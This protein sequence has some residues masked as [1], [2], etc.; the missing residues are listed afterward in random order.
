MGAEPRI[1][2]VAYWPLGMFPPVQVTEPPARDCVQPAFASASSR[3]NP[4]G[5]VN[6]TRLTPSASSS[7][8]AANVRSTAAPGAALAGGTEGCA[9]AGGPE[10]RNGRQTG[11]GRH[12]QGVRAHRPP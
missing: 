2:N 3:S 5:G 6:V 8:G 4:A 7:F 9:P 1:E 10:E 11:Q 12:E